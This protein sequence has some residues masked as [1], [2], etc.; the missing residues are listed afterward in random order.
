MARFF[1]AAQ[2]QREDYNQTK[3]YITLYV[4]FSTARNQLSCGKHRSAIPTLYCAAIKQRLLS[5]LYFYYYYLYTE[6]LLYFDIQV[7]VYYADPE[8][9]S[10]FHC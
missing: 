5:E 10:I 6:K 9:G 2:F 8:D 1:T 7:L 3:N 4:D